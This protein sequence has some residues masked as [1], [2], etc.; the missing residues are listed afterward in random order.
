M[1]TRM[2]QA[3]PGSFHL[4]TSLRDFWTLVLAD[5]WRTSSRRYLIVEESGESAATGLAF[6]VRA[7]HL[8]QTF[9]LASEPRRAMVIASMVKCARTSDDRS[10]RAGQLDP[11]G[12]VTAVGTWE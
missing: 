1:K 9:P 6:T 12:C 11:H 3:L 2:N 5:V 10:L 7:R 8:H 4:L